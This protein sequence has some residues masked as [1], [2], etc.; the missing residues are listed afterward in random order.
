ML[1]NLLTPLLLI[2]I[3]I[4]NER[5]LKIMSTN[6]ENLKTIEDS[7]KESNELAEKIH[8]EIKALK[9]R[10]ED[11]LTLDFT[12]A[13]TLAGKLTG[14]LKDSDAENPDETV[15]GSTGDDTLTGAA[16][17]DGTATEGDAST[18]G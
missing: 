17:N 1:W 5:K 12:N 6:S 10:S 18:A 13:L 14:T 2:V 3:V 11:G 16:G 7:L 15:Q 4:Q 8:G 9:A